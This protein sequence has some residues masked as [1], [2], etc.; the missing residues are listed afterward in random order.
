MRHPIERNFTMNNIYVPDLSYSCYT[1]IDKDTIRAYTKTPYNPGYNQSINIDYRDYYINSN[2][3][4]KDGTQQFSSYTTLPV[5][6]DKTLLTNEVY[7]R[8]DF[9]KILIIFII[10]CIIIF[11]IPLKIFLR[12]FKRFR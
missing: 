12:F 9:D 6:L 8:N 1:L 3:L 5:C 2:Y 11:G 10:L 4:Y 7:Y